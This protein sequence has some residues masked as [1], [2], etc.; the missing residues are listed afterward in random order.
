MEIKRVSITQSLEIITDSEV[1]SFEYYEWDSCL[2]RDGL[3]LICKNDE[4]VQVFNMNKVDRI[5]RN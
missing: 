1:I 2:V 4:I 3:V 5:V